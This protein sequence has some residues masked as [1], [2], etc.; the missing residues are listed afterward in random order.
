MAK[1]VLTVEYVSINA[2]DESANI[3]KGEL[4]LESDAQDTTT[5]GDAGW[6]T[7]LGGLKSGTLDLD[8]LNDVAAS[9][10]DGRLFA[11]FG[12]VVAFEVRV[13]N[14]VVGTSNPKYTGS[15]LINKHQPVGG[16]V[17]DVNAFSLSLP[18]TGAVAR[19]TA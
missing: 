13:S 18:T 9:Q 11:L 10:I 19:A 1:T 16:S 8:V 3:K 4:T 17:G 12:T 7:F 14:A 6:K 15:V 2:V 5:F